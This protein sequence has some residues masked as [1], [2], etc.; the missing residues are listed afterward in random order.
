MLEKLGLDT[1]IRGE[2]LSI[3]EYAKIA[4]Y[5]EDFTEEEL[6]ALQRRILA[7]VKDYVKP[8]G[9]LLYSTCTINR[10]ENEENAQWFAGK[11]PEFSLVREQQRLPG[12][13][14]GDGF[15]LALFRRRDDE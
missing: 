10:R 1:Q 14:E 6:A 15:Y 7:V 13:D 5:V 9:K 8:G 12:K 3:E 4:K 2:R 11:Y